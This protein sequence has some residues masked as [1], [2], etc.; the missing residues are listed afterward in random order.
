[1]FNKDTKSSPLFVHT[2]Q[3]QSRKQRQ[4]MASLFSDLHFMTYSLDFS[5]H[6]QVEVAVTLYG[7]HDF[8]R[9]Q[10]VEV[11]VTSGA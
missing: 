3:L 9:R 1:M 11:A 6:Q 2:F 8:S 5:R 4:L 7:S 10:Q